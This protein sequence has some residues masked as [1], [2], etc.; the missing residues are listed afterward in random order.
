MLHTKGRDKLMTK[1]SI[2]KLTRRKKESAPQGRITN[3]TVAEHREH[4]LAGGRRFKYP[5]QY[6]RHKLV[7][8]TIIVSVA[9]VVILIILTWW[10]L[11]VVQ[12]TGAFFY[13]VTQIL[14]VPVAMADGTNV[15]YSDYLLYY[16]P[17]EYYL[18]K[19]DEIKRDSEDGRLQL[20]YKKRD[21]MDRA[22][23]DAIARRIARDRGITVSS[24]EVDN[25][26][27]ALRQADNGTLSE[28][29]VKSSAQRVFGM[30]EQ[31]TRDQYRRSLL[32]GKAA[33]A[34]DDAARETAGTIEQKLKT[35]NPELASIATQ[36]N[37]ERKG[38][39]EYN[40]SGLISSSIVFSGVRVSDIAKLDTDKITGPLVSFTDDGYLFVK[41]L[42]KNDRQV[43]F[44]YIHV[45]LTVF[46]ERIATLKADDK[47]D[48]YITID[49]DRY[50]KQD[51]S[52]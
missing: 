31:D 3:E 29:A 9:A 1:L 38:S 21:A 25:A 11:Y 39:V 16:R 7:F 33:F 36:L 18:N 41:V 12:N 50:M 2:K 51:E 44:E 52:Q 15:K 20:E 4:I 42:K 5:V 23:S 30:S 14:P 26:L 35:K 46:A 49:P 17:S 32:R 47:V 40:V 13:R 48:E 45:P 43:S 27:A 34:I 19:Y 6:A 24:D 37:K 8:N 28:E 10:Q 22:I